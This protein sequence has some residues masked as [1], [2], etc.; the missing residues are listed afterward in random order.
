M[1]VNIG[2][3]LDEL[4]SLLFHF[5]LKNNLLILA[6]CLFASEIVQNKVYKKKN[7]T[8]FNKVDENTW[9][10]FEIAVNHFKSW[11]KVL[12][13]HRQEENICNW[14]SVDRHHRDSYHIFLQHGRGTPPINNRSSNGDKT[15]G[16]GPDQPVWGQGIC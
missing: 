15:L 4:C 16:L 14:L 1:Y 3:G 10:G 8:S 7:L 12:W 9:L 2:I 11:F 13:T 6:I 5:G